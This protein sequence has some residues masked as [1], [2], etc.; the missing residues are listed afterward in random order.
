MNLSEYS[1]FDGLGL[2]GLV[3]RGEV[4]PREGQEITWVRAVRLA[5]YPITPAGVP[6]IPTLRDLFGGQGG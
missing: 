5:D 2:A 4:S 3:A 6:L 1:A